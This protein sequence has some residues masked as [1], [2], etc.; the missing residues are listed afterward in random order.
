MKYSDLVQF[1]P[2]ENVVHVREADDHRIAEKLVRTY[3]ISDRMADVIL[4][5]ILPT[6]SLERSEDN[7]GL[8]IVGY[9]GTGKSHLMALIS[10]IAEHAELLSEVTHPA[11]QQGLQPIA[12]R[13]SVIRQEIGNSAMTLRDIVLQYLQEGLARMGVE[14]HFPP[15]NQVPNTKDLLQNAIHAFQAKYPRQGLLIVIDELLD[16]LQG[17]NERELIHDLSFLREIGEICST[18]DLR[19]IAGLQESLFD[20]PRFQFA[21]DSIRRVRDRYQQV[22][23]VREDV[24]FV[25]SRRLLAKYE[26][27]RQQIRTYLQKFTPLYDSMAERLED[28]VAL[29]PIH[30]AYLEMFER[31]TVIEKRQALKA[32]SHEIRQIL[33]QEVPEDRPG[34]ISFDAFWRLILEDPSYRAIPEIR[35]VMDK[36]QVLE[37]RVRNALSPIYRDAA[38]RI[39]HSLSLHRLTTGDL[40]V[41]IG[42]TPRELRDRLCLYLPIPE[43]DATFLL[44]SVENVLQEISRTVSGQFLSRNPEND[45]YYL[46]L[47]K[48]ID[49]DA[50]IEQRAAVLDPDTLDRYYFDALRRL[51]ELS[52]STYRTGFRIWQVEI[53]WQ[54]HGITRDGYIFLGTRDELSTTHPERD[55]Y[56]HF[57]HLFKTNGK[58]DQPRSDEIFFVL[59]SPQEDFLRSLRLYAGARE[60]STISSGSNKMQYEKKAE[61]HLRDLSRWIREYFDKAFSI[62]YGAVSR[63]VADYKGEYR[64]FRQEINLRDQIYQLASAILQ[65]VFDQKY[66]EYP[67]FVGMQ[68]TLKSLPE[69]AEWAI[70]AMTGGS[71][72]IQAQSILEGLDLLRKEN[73]KP[74]FTVLES[75][76]ARAVLNKL[77][78]LPP[79]QVLNRKDLIA[80]PDPRHE[81]RE[82]QFG[83]E[84]ELLMVVLAAL[85]RQGA[86][87]IN[88]MG[89][90]FTSDDL[91]EVAR[92]KIEDFMQFSAISRPKPIP[93]KALKA[94]LQGLGFPPE[95]VDYSEQHERMV[96]ELNQFANEELQRLVMVMDGLRDGLQYWGEPVLSS[97]EIQSYRKS[98]DNYKNLLEMIQRLNTPGRLQQFSLEVGEVQAQLKGRDTLKVLIMLRD[99]LQSVQSH[100]QYITRADLHLPEHHPW[101]LEAQRLRNEHL[102]WLRNPQQRADPSLYSRLNGGLSNLR[103]SYA[104]AYLN[105]HAR[106][107]LDRLGDERKQ[108]L[109]QNPHWRHLLTLQEVII[110]PNSEL[111]RLQ[112]EFSELRSCPNLTLEDLSKYT[113]CPHCGFDP[114]SE[115]FS[116]S[117]VERLEKLE[118]NLNLVH[119]KWIARLREELQKP[120]VAENITL[121]KS[122]YREQIKEFVEKGE[123]TSPVSRNLVEAIN[124]ALRG[125]DKVVLEGS[126]FLIALTQPG[127]PCTIEELYQR[128]KTLLD[129]KIG[130]KDLTKVRIEIDW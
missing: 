102:T 96:Q 28:F 79:A 43:T 5:R 27:Q 75:R 106:A 23:I 33:Q 101:H 107:R 129:K 130:D 59:E 109:T 30:P 9:Y 11:V 49:F 111:T 128:L 89:K 88:W 54:G 38:I 25:V 7:G 45:Q 32:V 80:P 46:D 34:L 95:W 56:I 58:N 19:F 125:L 8:F 10:A 15:M 108:K 42:L 1:E 114:R 100:L 118:E 63:R 41:P 86:I 31:V 105:L 116:F 94:L 50:Q 113:E 20:S 13:F 117:A 68:L 65:P 74:V 37:E 76:Y 35:E 26:K 87:T 70:R 22:R 124:D 60:M 4:L 29:F 82:V 12:G 55:F 98:L 84:P 91:N 83:L 17:R 48:D 122:P 112:K 3:V 53:P 67:S 52:D 40:R 51:L 119:S 16:Y 81:E 90:T 93:E 64:L 62:R 126:D 77:D 104:Q 110:L 123:F 115:M 92:L 24:A 57:L 121:L 6:I 99:V 39:I 73:N 66:P 78:T 69:A 97:D 47:D 44:T 18:T 61:N 36:S 2:V 72:N 103:S 14:V 71:M 21:A 85:L 120:E 127:M